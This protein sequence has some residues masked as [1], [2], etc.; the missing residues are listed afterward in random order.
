MAHIYIHIPFCKRRCVYCDFYKE[1]DFSYVAQFEAALMKEI[2]ISAHDLP[3]AEISTLYVGGG[4]PSVLSLDFYARVLECLREVFSFSESIEMTLEVNPGDADESW[5]RGLRALGFNRLSVGIQSLEDSVLLFLS[6]RH[7]AVEALRCLDL[8]QA[9]GF[10]NVS[11][12]VI[13][14]IPG[15]T[16]AMLCDTLTVLCGYGLPH[17]SAY[18]LTV[19]Q[20]T[21]LWQK[22]VVDKQLAE[23]LNDEG[24]FVRHYKLVCDTLREGGFEHYEVSNFARNGLISRHNTSYWRGVPYRGFGPSAHSFD[25]ISRRW[26]VSVLPKYIEQVLAGVCYYDSELLTASDRYNET[27]MTLLR[28]SAGIP[29]DFVAT[30][31]APFR[32][33][34]EQQLVP[35]LAQGL[36]RCESGF[37]VIPELQWTICDTIIKELIYV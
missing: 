9:A 4:T 22:S 13:Y 33:Y 1:T 27:V 2:R 20:G 35:L 11:A 28:T 37:Y 16:D 14:G 12:D 31:A 5:F 3:Q 29:L 18:Q 21:A 30:L 34:F 17:I 32:Q 7:T 15:L 23:A 24:L 8:I 25:G 26:N 10:Q 19:E 6:R 36:L